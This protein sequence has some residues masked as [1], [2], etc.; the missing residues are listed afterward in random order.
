[1]NTQEV[2]ARLVQLCREGKNA[3]AINELYDDHI[4]SREPKGSPME[5]TEGKAA[6][7]GKTQQWYEMVEEIHS[8][9]ISDPVVSGNFFSCSM[10]MDVTYKQHAGA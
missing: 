8:G 5:I 7:S 3:D 9:E 6:V 2:A 10:D 4:V 1:M